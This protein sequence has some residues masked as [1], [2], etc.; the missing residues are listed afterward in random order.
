MVFQRAW[1]LRTQI[2]VRL[3]AP[4]GKA[5]RD[6][7][8]HKEIQP[9]C[10][11]PNSLFYSFKTVWPGHLNTGDE[12]RNHTGRSENLCGIQNPVDPQLTAYVLIF[13]WAQQ[14]EQPFVP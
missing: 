10:S 13:P 7:V 8:R 12:I 2:A 1:S 4:G 14:F 5:R 11:R 3:R 9:L 6:P